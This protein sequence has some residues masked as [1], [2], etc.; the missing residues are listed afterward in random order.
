[1]RQIRRLFAL[2]WRAVT[3]MHTIQ[4]VI[5]MILPS[6]LVTFMVAWLG[7]HSIADLTV[8]FIFV[9]SMSVLTEIVTIRRGVLGET[10]IQLG[11]ATAKAARGAE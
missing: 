7:G 4:W 8:V 9:A 1:V 10:M 2:G 6:T 11:D 3:E 5:E